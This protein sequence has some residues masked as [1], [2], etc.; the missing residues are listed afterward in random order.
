MICANC[1]APNPP[2]SLYCGGCGRVLV[3]VASALTPEIP[4]QSSP[5]VSSVPEVPASEQNWA[6]A[7]LPTVRMAPSGEEQQQVVEPTIAQTAPQASPSGELVNAASG[8]QVVSGTLPTQGE[9]F[10]PVQPVSPTPVLAYPAQ[11]ISPSFTPG[12]APQGYPPAV[13][14]TEFP[15]GIYP[16][17]G[18]QGSGVYPPAYSG[19]PSQPGFPGYPGQPSQPGWPGYSGQPSQPGLP[20][21]SGQ[22]SQPGLPGYSGQSSQPG[23]PSYPG[24]PSQPN[25][26]GYPGMAAQPQPRGTSGLINPLP[27]W[28]FIVSVAVI[29][30]VLALLFLFGGSDWAAG[31]Q[32]AGVVAMVLG[33]LIALGFIVRAVMGMLSPGNPHRRAQVISSLLLVLLL[34]GFSVIILTQQSGVHAM[35]ARFLEGQKQ[36]Q[37][38]I[39]EFQQSGQ[40]TPT[41]VDIARVYNE[42][43]TQ[44]LSDNQFDNAII[45]FD[46]VIERYN[47]VPDQVA[48]AQTNEISAY[49]GQGRKAAQG[50]DFANA[51]KNFDALLNKPF[52]QSNNDCKATTAALDATAYYNLGEKQLGASDFAGA[53]KSFETLTTNPNLQSAP[54]V[55]K[56][57][58]DY[59]KALLGEG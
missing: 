3:P 59:A 53:V 18:S 58:P 4:A 21:Y 40:G 5:N 49:Q 57:H 16:T 23:F 11:Q 56:A 25:W 6:N 28:A 36:W 30:V 39:D 13:S 31:A 45:Q 51:T 46:T 17:P 9:N 27:R 35:Q 1:G 44:L 43:G 32:T 24:Q 48:K 22:P 33:A 50:G 34:L 14:G 38:A 55:Q 8:Q 2:E 10:S 54:E 19:Q 7:D 26:T 37:S 42:W 15:A 52:C 12:N 29:V 47:Q 20:G 41:S